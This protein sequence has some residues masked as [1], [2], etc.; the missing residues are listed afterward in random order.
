MSE[1]R[2]DSRPAFDPK[3]FQEDAFQT[4]DVSYYGGLS[5]AVAGIVYTALVTVAGVVVALIPVHGWVRGALVAAYVAIAV[6]VLWAALRRGKFR[7]ALIRRFR[8]VLD[9][10]EGR[11]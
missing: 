11:G 8:K 2:P 6:G 4:E 1:D 3:V 10:P 7:N 5:L 9:L